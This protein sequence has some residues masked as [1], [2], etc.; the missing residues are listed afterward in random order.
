MSLSSILPLTLE[1]RTFLKVLQI[2]QRLCRAWAVHR[3][4]IAVSELTPAQLR[5]IGLMPDCP[6]QDLDQHQRYWRDRLSPGRDG[7]F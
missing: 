6:L 7:W 1:A 3:T 4:R 5:D 2:G